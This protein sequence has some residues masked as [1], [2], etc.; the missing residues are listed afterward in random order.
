M[1]SVKLSDVVAEEPG[2]IV[3]EDASVPVPRIIARLGV[4]GVLKTCSL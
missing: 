3:V 2:T 4:I 1:T